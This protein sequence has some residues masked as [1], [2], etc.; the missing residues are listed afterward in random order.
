MWPGGS[1]RERWAHAPYDG[2]RIFLLES[3]PSWAKTAVL[4]FKKIGRRHT[5]RGSAFLFRIPQATCR[6]RDLRWLF[7]KFLHG[8]EL[9]GHL[10]GA[11][12]PRTSK[13]GERVWKKGGQFSLAPKNNHVIWM[14]NLMEIS[15]FYQTWSNSMISPSSEHSKLTVQKGWFASM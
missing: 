15:F 7:S 9:R 1:W 6:T 12:A 8:A 3:V 11:A 2:A 13:S 10:Y 5:E 4:T 14:Q